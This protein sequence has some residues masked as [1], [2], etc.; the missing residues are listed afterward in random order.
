MADSDRLTSDQVNTDLE[1]REQGSGRDRHAGAK[2]SAGGAVGSANKRHLRILVFLTG[3]FSVPIIIILVLIWLTPSD[4]F[5]LH[6]N[7]QAEPLDGVKGW[8][9]IRPE[10]GQKTEL[11]T[12][13]VAK[14]ADVVRLDNG[15]RSGRQAAIPAEGHS[16]PERSSTST[17]AVPESED[18]GSAL[19]MVGCVEGR[20][21]PPT[22]AFSQLI[23]AR[24]DYPLPHPPRP[25]ALRYRVDDSEEFKVSCIFDGIVASLAQPPG[26]RDHLR[27]P[28][29]LMLDSAGQGR[30]L[31]VHL[32]VDTGRAFTAYFDVSQLALAQVRL[33]GECGRP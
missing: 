32:R 28:G 27:D 5:F 19:F 25:C 26:P 33:Q 29:Q 22:F 14:A 8:F 4:S 13:A 7:V 23:P 2:D 6:F 21:M 9:M 1:S 3:L 31:T 10:A 16:P 11:F 20:I 30:R 12:L 15:G 18:P 17:R 24:R